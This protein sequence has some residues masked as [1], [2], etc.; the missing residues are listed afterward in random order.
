MRRI[1]IKRKYIN[2]FQKIMKYAIRS[3]I[4]FLKSLCFFYTNW[5][6]SLFCV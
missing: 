3:Y 2:A 6:I 1:D 4:F 5:F